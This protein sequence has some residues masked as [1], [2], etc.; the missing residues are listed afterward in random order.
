MT[1]HREERR[2][3]ILKLYWPIS[4]KMKQ[5]IKEM[6]GQGIFRGLPRHSGFP[7]RVGVNTEQIIKEIKSQKFDVKLN[8]YHPRIQ[9][10]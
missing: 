4:F 7:K 9:E 8:Q 1:V 2:Q 5:E 6:G 3:I 10:P